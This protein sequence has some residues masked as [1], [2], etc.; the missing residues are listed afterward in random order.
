[1]DGEQND[2]DVSLKSHGQQEKRPTNAIKTHID[3]S[4]QWMILSMSDEQQI[5]STVKQPQCGRNVEIREREVSQIDL[6]SHLYLNNQASWTTRKTHI[7]NDGV[8]MIDAVTPLAHQRSTM[9]LS[10]GFRGI[11]ENVGK[12]RQ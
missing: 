2:T 4:H 10:N 7:F 6:N 12:T 1:M 5:A 8:S 3:L 9:L 11:A